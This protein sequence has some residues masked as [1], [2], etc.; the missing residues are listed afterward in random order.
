[1]K[2]LI[3][4]ILVIVAVSGCNGIGVGGKLEMFRVDERQDSSRTYRQAMPFKCYFTQC[5]QP[6][7]NISGS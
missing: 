5:E 3:G 6:T 4:V 7:D 1:M 2:R